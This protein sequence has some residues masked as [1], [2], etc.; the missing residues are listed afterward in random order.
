MLK[1]YVATLTGN[2]IADEI[3]YQSKKHK[4]L[5]TKYFITN[6]KPKNQK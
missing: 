6:M 5:H 1:T 4:I 3:I 2:F